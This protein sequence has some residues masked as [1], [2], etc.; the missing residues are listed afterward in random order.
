MNLSLI[1]ASFKLIAC[2]SLPPHPVLR[3]HE[4]PKSRQHQFTNSIAKLVT[5]HGRAT[6]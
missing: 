5:R 3:F 1:M 2:P 4:H 6:T